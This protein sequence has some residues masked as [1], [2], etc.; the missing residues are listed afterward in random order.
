MFLSHLLLRAATSAQPSRPIPFIIWSSFVASHQPPKDQPKAARLI[1]PYS[2]VTAAGYDRLKRL[3]MKIKSPATTPAKIADADTR[4][5][6]DWLF[7]ASD[8]MPDMT[9]PN[10]TAPLV[11]AGFGWVGLSSLMLFLPLFCEM[12]FHFDK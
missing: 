7:K 4:I 3:T 10:I 12:K 6:R 1:V 9:M 8:T 2:Q 11:C 5:H